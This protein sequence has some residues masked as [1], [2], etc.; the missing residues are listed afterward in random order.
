MNALLIFLQEPLPGYINT[1][2]GSSVEE[3]VLRYK[4]M[5]RVLLKQL[6]GLTHTHVRFCFY[7]D[8]AEEA[9]AFWILPQ[10]RG[11]C[12][13]QA[14][15]YLYT[16]DKHAPTWSI[17]FRAQGDGSL[18]ERVGCATAQAFKEGYE[19]VAVLD[20][21][22]ID[23]GARWLNMAFLQTTSKRC[24]IGLSKNGGVYLHIQTSEHPLV[25]L[26]NSKDGF[27]LLPEIQ[28]VAKTNGIEV[29]TL[30]E[31]LCVRDAESWAIAL[32]SP[33]GGK[34]RSAMRAMRSE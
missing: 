31:L 16:P 34:L 7:P 13:K 21:I 11:K 12:I 17:D 30:P 25:C 23:C 3:S 22:C 18:G 19:K 6:E 26:D 15:H 32:Q 14:N 29:N 4:A 5:I 1:G 2:L 28:L 10:L 9:V 8:D 20:P 33:I 24:T 27:T